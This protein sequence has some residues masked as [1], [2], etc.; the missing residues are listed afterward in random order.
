MSV[1][2][3]PPQE[4]QEVWPR[5]TEGRE[6][7]PPPW[8]TAG[9]VLHSSQKKRKQADPGGNHQG[10]GSVGTGECVVASNFQC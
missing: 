2:V 5:R 4:K 3:T 9:W 10:P 7:P 1:Q 6:D 8:L